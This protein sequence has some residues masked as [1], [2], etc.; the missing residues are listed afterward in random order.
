MIGLFL[1]APEKLLDLLNTST[2]DE[3]VILRFVTFLA[4][5][6]HQVKEKHITSSSLPT[7]EK[8]PSPETMYTA[9]LGLGNV[10]NLKNKVF[11]LCKHDNEDIR[12][13]AARVHA[14]LK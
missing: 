2:T 9:L 1:Q 8:A 4:N 10:G 14:Q 6:L 5:V 7:D 13:Q 12:T 11:L 3:G